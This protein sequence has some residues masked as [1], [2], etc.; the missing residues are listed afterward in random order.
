MSI[1]R[2]EFLRQNKQVFIG[3][4]TKDVNRIIRWG[5]IILTIFVFSVFLLFPI[6]GNNLF[7]G[8][9]PLSFVLVDLMAYIVGI[10][11]L[12]LFIY[13][14]V[15]LNK[16]RLIEN[17]PT[18]KVRALAMGLVEIYGEVISAGK[19]LKSPFANKDCVYY[20][21][22]IEE[23]RRSG[24]SSRWVTIDSGSD[25]IY[26]YLRDDTG[27]VLVE[28][29][30]ADIDIPTDFRFNSGIRIDPPQ[31]I[32]QFLKS[33][34]IGSEGIF[35]INKKMLYL[36]WIIVPKDKLYIMG[37]AGDNPYVEEG[38]SRTNVGDIIVWKGNNKIY[39]ISDKSEKVILKNLKYK[40]IFWIM[41]GG[42]LILLS[43]IILYKSLS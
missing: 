42:I 25:S 15:C 5:R 27:Y 6:V 24:K 2:E 43:G 28:P 37:T 11:G 41:V 19:L 38:T 34:N 8:F 7:L 4:R 31:Q 35:R 9:N 40:S 39:Y 22:K 36:E 23:Y 26:F 10:V 18:S 13:G 12:I 3:N 29:T 21:Y 17:T 1:S 30:G 14:F 20:K 33:R 32:R 16:K